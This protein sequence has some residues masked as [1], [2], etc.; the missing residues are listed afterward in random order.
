MDCTAIILC[1]GKALRAGG[2]DKGLVR[3]YGR[4]LVQQA[5]DTVSGLA[6][7]AV[8]SANR[9]LDRYAEFGH[10]I[11]AD[12][13]TGFQGP[14]AGLQAGL[15]YCET[16]VALVLPC[17]MPFLTEAIL[18]RVLDGLGSKALCC[19]HDGQRDQYL[20]AALRT[21]LQTHL[22]HFLARGERAVQRWYAELDSVT[23]DCS[24]AAVSFQ[25]FNAPQRYG[26]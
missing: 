9:N 10:P 3:V 8:I 24:D 4:P 16:S 7:N 18:A 1:G 15:A 2:R 11:V 5:L 26:F 13:L 20:V 17:D 21:D 14:L 25:H 19:A 23:V 22:A 6:S 12:T